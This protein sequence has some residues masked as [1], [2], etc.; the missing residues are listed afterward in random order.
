[1]SACPLLPIHLGPGF[2]VRPNAD[3]SLIASEAVDHLASVYPQADRLYQL[4]QSSGLTGD[5]RCKFGRRP[6]IDLAAL[7]MQDVL[8]RGRPENVDDVTI[9]LFDDS[10]RSASRS[11][12]SYPLLSFE[13]R[14]AR[15]G[16]GRN[17]RCAAEA[18]RA[19]HGKP[20]QPGG[21]NMRQDVRYRG[22]RELRFSPEQGH[23]QIPA[24]FVLH[25]RNLD[26]RQLSKEFASE[27]RHGTVTGRGEEDGLGL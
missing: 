21:I 20:F 4:P 6:R 3:M 5:E 19:R 25:R 12:H 23:R 8:K 26:C 10:I 24:S 11:H 9:D 17:I 16:C 14:Q 15:F 2:S 22:E 18:F 13:A 27:M 7:D 1:M